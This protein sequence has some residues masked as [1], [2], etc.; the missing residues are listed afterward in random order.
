MTGRPRTHTPFGPAFA[1]VGLAATL[2]AVAGCAPAT[3]DTGHP[4]A[5]PSAAA[6]GPAEAFHALEA[7]L[8][9][10]RAARASFRITAEGA[11]AVTLDGVLVMAGEDGL[12]LDAAG[13][14]GDR[15]V[16]LELRVADGVM[17]GSNGV[18]TFSDRRGERWPGGP[19]PDPRGRPGY[20]RGGAMAGRGRAST[21]ARS[22]RTVP[23]GG[24]EGA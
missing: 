19:L 9:E 24:D 13:T 7:R 21:A 12:S 15:V 18:D 3:A 11:L 1:L 23:A 4:G 6:E 2:A 14:F 22:D 8:L 5:P 17:T 16:R 10:T 20:G